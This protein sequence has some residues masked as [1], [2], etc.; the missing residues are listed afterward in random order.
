MT[1][2]TWERLDNASNIFLAARTD[3]DPKVFRVTAELE[4]NVDQAILQQAVDEVYDRYPLYH[5]VLRRGV[6]WHYLQDSTLRPEVTTEQLPTCAPIYDSVRRTLLFRVTHYRQRINLQVLH[7][8]SDST[9]ALLYIT[10]VIAD[11]LQLHDPQLAEAST[12]NQQ[13]SLIQELT[14]DSLAEYFRPKH[15]SKKRARPPWKT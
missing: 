11:Y 14:R 6:F 10:D 1:H 13:T 3:S 9:A 8:R 5:A 2:Q 4:H 15:P 7:S 12:E